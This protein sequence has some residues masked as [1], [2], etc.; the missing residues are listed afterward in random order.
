MGITK[1]NTRVPNRHY[2]SYVVRH[3]ASCALDSQAYV[4][5]GGRLVPKN[6]KLHTQKDLLVAIVDA[7]KAIFE[8]PYSVY[9]GRGP[10]N[11][12][13]VAPE[14]GIRATQG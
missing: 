4:R 13:R 11:K 3:D 12:Q 5:C 8:L 14:F 10:S 9:R 1:T 2:L 6:R 7:P